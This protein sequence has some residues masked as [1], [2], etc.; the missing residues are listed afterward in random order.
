MNQNLRENGCLE[1]SILKNSE[2]IYSIRKK[3]KDYSKINFFEQ[4]SLANLKPAYYR[5]HVSI[6]NKD[7]KELLSEEKYFYISQFSSLPRPW[8]LSLSGPSSE[9]PLYTNILGN[10]FLN[11]NNLHEALTL[12]EDAY[13]KKPESV[14]FAFDY[15]RALFKAEEYHEVK[16]IAFPFM[17][18]PE[19]FQFLSL[20]GNSYQALG[21]YSEAIS[22]YKEYL[23]HYGTNINILN[24]LGKCYYNLGD[25]EEALNTW[26]KSLEI[27]RNQEQLRKV[28]KVLKKEK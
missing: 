2:I 16:K 14:R 5:I 24:S 21:E 6:L 1:Y 13:S 28:V 19:K 27:E 12:L 4:F 25:K 18:R 22:H 26:E 8:I 7:K 23:S 11:K 17:E 10:Q 9:N 3:I 15:A 20:L